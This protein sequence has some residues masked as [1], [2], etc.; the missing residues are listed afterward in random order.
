V[1]EC[2]DLIFGFSLLDYATTKNLPDGEVPKVVKCC[3][4]EIDKRGLEAEGIY[5]VRGVFLSADVSSHRLNTGF[6]SSCYCAV[7]ESIFDRR[8]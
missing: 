6:G 4:A 3:I 2:H 7:R 8:T 1:G 5:R